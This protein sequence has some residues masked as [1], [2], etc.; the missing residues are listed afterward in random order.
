MGV[1]EPRRQL[2]LALEPAQVL[3]PRGVRR[4]KLDRRR[5]AQHLVLGAIDDAHAPL[6]DLLEERVLAEPPRPGDRA[7]QVEGHV[8][9]ER[10]EESDEGRPERRLRHDGAGNQIAEGP[11][12]EEEECHE[13]DRGHRDGRDP[14]RAAG[15]ARHEGGAPE[16]DRV[17]NEQ[18]ELVRPPRERHRQ[19]HDG[20]SGGRGDRA[21]GVQAAQA[22]IGQG[23]A[24]RGHPDE[25]E[26]RG[27]RQVKDREL[28]ERGAPGAALRDRVQND[29]H[30]EEPARR[31]ACDAA[32]ER[33]A[34]R[35]EPTL[36]G[37]SARRE[38]RRS[39]RA[40]DPD[41]LDVR[42]ERRGIRARVE[43]LPLHGIES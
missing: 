20:V 1:G 9:D 36:A 12:T 31:E 25:T 38:G 18:H 27:G 17:Q 7:A 24:P 16:K 8:R 34:L 23:I 41:G 30:H 28:L 35:E 39:V 5:P 43:A 33:E 21:R 10:R 4:E 6:P 14:R 22:S 15:L 13:G 2:R 32:E 40:D 26:D 29:A 42:S 19:R 3:F 11:M 37:R